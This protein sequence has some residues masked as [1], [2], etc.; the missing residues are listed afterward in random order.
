MHKLRTQLVLV[1]T[2]F[3]MAVALLTRI[4]VAHYLP[5]VWEDK[6]LAKSALWY[7]VVGAVIA[8][9]L[10]MWAWVLPDDISP[11]VAA[12]VIT[13]SWVGMTGALHL[14]GV[15][16]CVDAMYAGHSVSCV[17]DHSD[18]NDEAHS[19]KKD[20]VFRVLKEP[21]VGAMAVV[22]LVLLLFSK[23][24]LIANLW[25]TLGVSLV[26]SIAV[27]RAVA[28][29]FMVF[30]PYTPYASR[31]GLGAVIARHTSRNKALAV[32]GVLF[33]ILLFYLPL[34][35]VLIMA[36][37]VGLVFYYWRSYWVKTLGGFVGDAVGA[38]IEVAEVMIL[39][40]LYCATL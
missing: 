35:I 37:S 8:L 39:F 22:A 31:G 27:A 17:P 10:M 29:L 36:A 26:L 16:D 11:W 4:P 14:D 2:P 28:V 19:L 3:L 15:A 1:F 6:A 23:V 25:P 7:P 38:L 34:S 9:V 24:I 13:M 30:T 12:I 20:T 40:V 21:S 33:F 32:S 18:D 5:H